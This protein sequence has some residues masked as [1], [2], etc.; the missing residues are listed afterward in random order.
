MMQ[1]RPGD[2]G[3]WEPFEDGQGNSSH[4]DWVRVLMYMM[5]P[6]SD[7]PTAILN[8]AEF[9][10]PGPG[11]KMM[12]D[13]EKMRLAEEYANLAF[14]QMNAPC[15]LVSLQIEEHE[16][17]LAVGRLMIAEWERKQAEDAAPEPEPEDDEDDDPDEGYEPDDDDD[18]D[19]RAGP[20]RKPLCP[21]ARQ[22]FEPVRSA[23]RRLPRGLQ[24]ANP[25]QIAEAAAAWRRLPHML[26]RPAE[27]DKLRKTFTG[28]SSGWR[29]KR[30]ST[31][32]TSGWACTKITAS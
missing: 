31:P 6:V 24:I 2:Q 32:R 30:K 8:S 25:A 5:R 11:G 22:A 1:Q 3:D 19:E 13:T 10:I 9:W 28:R 17:F 23:R 20:G 12:R 27:C 4:S 7:T 26:S 18:D 16:Y 21:G 14:E 15:N 29:G